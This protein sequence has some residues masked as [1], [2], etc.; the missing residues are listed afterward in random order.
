MTPTMTILELYLDLLHFWS[1]LN[2]RFNIL[3]QLNQTLKRYLL[4]RDDIMQCVIKIFLSDIQREVEYLNI[5][6][7]DSDSDASFIGDAR[8][9]NKKVKYKKSDIKSLLIDFYGS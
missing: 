8:H 2:S 9:E 6:S 3:L 7:G 5:I 1:I 4:Q